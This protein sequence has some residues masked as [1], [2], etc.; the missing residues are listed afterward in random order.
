MEGEE[1][2]GGRRES[3]ACI[4]L[5]V[6]VSVWIEF[7]GLQREWQ[8]DSRCISAQIGMEKDIQGRSRS[9]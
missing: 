8:S 5:T 1:R 6:P 9:C 3:G 7:Q 2:I 4:R